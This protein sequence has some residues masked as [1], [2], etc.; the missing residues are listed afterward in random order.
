MFIP[1]RTMVLFDFVAEPVEK[2]DAR[3]V[4]VG[5]GIVE[6]HGEV[7]SFRSAMTSRKN[8]TTFDSNC[9]CGWTERPSSSSC[10]RS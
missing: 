2:P 9:Q 10:L 8:D 6:R 1:Q 4:C 7:N 5:L 3:L